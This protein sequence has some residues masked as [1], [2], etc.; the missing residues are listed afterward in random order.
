[1]Q[2]AGGSDVIS[3]PPILFLLLPGQPC[4]VSVSMSACQQVSVSAVQHIGKSILLPSHRSLNKKAVK[5][6]DIQTAIFNLLSIRRE[7][8]P[9]LERTNLMS[10]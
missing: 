4:L 10:R 9:D 8:I 1:M 5:D 6:L 3:Y 2:V 7:W